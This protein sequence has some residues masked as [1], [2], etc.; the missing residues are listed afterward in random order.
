MRVLAAAIAASLLALSAGAPAAAA[1]P[2][3]IRIDVAISG[4]TVGF[5]GGTA[6]FWLGCSGFGGP[7]QV[8]VDLAGLTGSGLLGPLPFG[9][10]CVI[11]DADPG[12]AGPMA[13]FEE[14]QISPGS[15][16]VGADV[17]A[18]QVGI[19]RSWSGVTPQWDWAGEFRLD[20]LTADRALVNRYGGLTI[21]GRAWCKSMAGLPVDQYLNVSWDATQYVGR[22]TAITAGY[23]PAIAFDC[24]DEAAPTA[25]VSWRTL[26]PGTQN[27]VEW[28]YASN[29]KFA[30][31]MVHVEVRI[32]SWQEL[33]S[34]WWDSSRDDYDSRCSTTP[35]TS[36]FF[37]ANGDGFCAYNVI[38]WGA[39]Q[40]DLRAARV[41]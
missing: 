5:S 39:E 21:E 36:G 38:V 8:D 12:D 34:Q 13:S 22:K 35:T 25:P 10:T 11:N 24:H 26:G 19:E 32:E 7:Q 1:D 37:D 2:G 17:V 6:T 18:F 30:A 41:R 29:G 16:T 4:Y 33:V 3:S 9:T 27:T 31:G 23:E 40:F 28:I 14:P 15:V 20:V